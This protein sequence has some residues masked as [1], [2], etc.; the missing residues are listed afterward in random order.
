M[1][2]SCVVTWASTHACVGMW[3]RSI[4]SASMSSSRMTV[5]TESVAGL[6][7]ITAS[8]QPYS[9]PSRI[10]AP[11]PTGSS[12]GWFGCR[13][14]ES[15]PGRPIVLR[16][17]VTTRHL[18]AARMRSWLRISLLTAATIS[19]V[20]PWRQFAQVPRRSSRS[21]TA[22]RETRRRSCRP[23]AR[24]RRVVRVDDQPRHFIVL[25]R[26]DRLIEKL[27]KRHIGQRHLRGHALFVVFGRDAGQRIAASRR[28]RLRQQ[29]LQAVEGVRLSC[30]RS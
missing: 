13:R 24:T 28:R 9:R 14:I 8:P 12:V 25:V 1:A 30:R 29:L 15:R 23:P 17:R 19:G 7:P 6:M 11:M 22:S 26:N 20:R 18:L 4:S 2:A 10:D 3:Y 27:P 5:S 16:N 21:T